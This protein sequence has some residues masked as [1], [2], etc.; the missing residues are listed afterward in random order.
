M[1]TPRMQQDPAE[2]SESVIDRQL[3]R[4]SRKAGGATASDLRRLWG[5]IASAKVQA[6][7]TIRPSV[8]DVEEARAWCEGDGDLLAKTGHSLTGKAA[9]VFDV[10]SADQDDEDRAH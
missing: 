5:D 3:A 9:L 6:I 7:L 10:L 2:G 4:E 1:A 8:A